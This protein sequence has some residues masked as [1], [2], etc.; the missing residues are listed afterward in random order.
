MLT[1]HRKQLLCLS[2]TSSW[3]PWRDKWPTGVGFLR[4]RALELCW[5]KSASCLIGFMGRLGLC[6]IVVIADETLDI[7]IQ[8]FN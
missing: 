5:G 4:E 8:P 3:S 1:E 7:T 6:L 2:Q